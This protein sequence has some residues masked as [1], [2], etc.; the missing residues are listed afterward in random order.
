MRGT[1]CHCSGARGRK[2]QHTRPHRASPCRGARRLIDAIATSLLPKARRE[3]RH[4]DEARHRSN[5]AVSSTRPPVSTAKAPPRQ[6]PSTIAQPGPTT[7]WIYDCSAGVPASTTRDDVPTDMEKVAEPSD[8]AT[9]DAPLW[10]ATGQ[11]RQRSVPARS[12]PGQQRLPSWTRYR[13]LRRCWYVSWPRKP[14]CC[15]A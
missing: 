7:I 14:S 11:P 13:Q 1:L 5:R 3:L 9:C 15:R 12:R 4:L 2:G 6:H 10:I 8:S